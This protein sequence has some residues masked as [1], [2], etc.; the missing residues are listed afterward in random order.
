MLDF[1]VIVFFTSLS[2]L[3]NARPWP[4]KR[5]YASAR[6]CGGST[7]QWVGW[8][9]RKGTVPGGYVFYLF[10]SLYSPLFFFLLFFFSDYLFF[11]VEYNNRLGRTGRDQHGWRYHHG[12]G[13]G[14]G[15][16]ERYVLCYYFVLSALLLSSSCSYFPTISFSSK[17]STRRGGTGR[18]G[19][20]QD[21]H[22]Q[23]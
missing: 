2:L 6:D 9:V 17:H 10:C 14:A 16:P 21:Q 15:G 4:K 19:A 22:E 11:S 13:R 23:W 8:A 12:T 3:T 18:D 1:W 7:G 20:R 5:W